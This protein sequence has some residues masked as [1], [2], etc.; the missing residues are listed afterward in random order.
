[1]DLHGRLL[2]KGLVQRGHRVT[3]IT[4]KRPDGIDFEQREGVQIHYLRHTVYGSRRRGWPSRSVAKMLQ[5]H[6]VDPFDLVWSQSFDAFGLKCRH[7]D[8]PIVPTIHGSIEQEFKTFRVNLRTHMRCPHHLLISLAGLFYSYVVV[9]R[10]LLS[11]ADRIIAVSEPVIKDIRKWYGNRLAQKCIVVENGVDTVVFRPDLSLRK[12]VRTLHH[13]EGGETLLLTLGR[14]TYEKG[15]HLA[16]QA[17]TKL[18]RE[19]RKAHLMVVG[20][21]SYHESLK[22]L[23]H[24]TSLGN[25]VIFVGAVDNTETVKY[26]NASDIFLMPSLTAEGLPFALLEAMSCAK[27]VIASRIGG[28]SHLVSDGDTGFL[29]KPGDVDQI[30]ARLGDLLGNRNL[31][32]RIGSSARNAVIQS[33]A[34]D[35]MV[36]MTIATMESVAHPAAIP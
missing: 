17:L 4:S 10:P 30:N 28:I 2:S 1:M 25:A 6:K 5:L 23:V 31:A 15:H 36:D 27:P 21:G 18:L 9:Q 13:I 32:A 19:G 8:I 14:L 33:F 29:V 11:I 26:Y 34:I 12:A 22:R 35:R 3:I 7:T 20:T 16:V 24:K